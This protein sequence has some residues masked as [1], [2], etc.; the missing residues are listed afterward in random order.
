MS[1]ICINKDVDIND[2]L[3]IK[4]EILCYGIKRNKVSDEIYD[5]E[6]KSKVKRTSNMELQLLLSEGII[7]SVPYN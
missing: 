1:D 4:S 6:H 5:M 7:A 3:K 2:L